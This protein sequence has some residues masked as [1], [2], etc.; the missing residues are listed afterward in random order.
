MKELNFS[1]SKQFEVI[2][3][4]K[5]VSEA[6]KEIKEGIAVIFVPHATAGIIINENYDPK[7][8]EDIITALNQIVP[9]R[10]NWKHDQVDGNAAAHIKSAIIGPSET[11]IIKDGKMQLGTWQQIALIDFDGPRERKVFVKTIK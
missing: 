1:T 3:I 7:V 5:E 8:S 6:V 9:L 10:N 4:T 11:V 2:D